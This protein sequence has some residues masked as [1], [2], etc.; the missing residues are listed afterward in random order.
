[1]KFS[2]EEINLA[3]IHIDPLITPTCLEH[4]D[5]KSDPSLTAHYLNLVGEIGCREPLKIGLCSGKYTLLPPY[6]LYSAYLE[7]MSED[8]NQKVG[9]VIIEFYDYSEMIAV[10]AKLSLFLSGKLSSLHKLLTLQLLIES[11]KTEIELKKYLNFNSANSSERRQI[12]RFL[13]LLRTPKILSRIL[14]IPVSE[15][16]GLL[17][18]KALLLPKTVEIDLTLSDA[19]KLLSVLKDDEHAIDE[20][21]VLFDE[22]KE[23]LRRDFITRE[24]ECK[25]MREWRSFNP[26]RMIELAKG[27]SLKRG[28]KT[29][30]KKHKLDQAWSITLDN[31]LGT[32]RIPEFTFTSFSK[33][34]DQGKKMVEAIYISQKLSQTLLGHVQR[35]R[36]AEHGD[37][38]KVD[39]ENMK[40]NNLR[41]DDVDYVNDFIRPNKLL[42]LANKERFLKAYKLRAH[43]F[44][45]ESYDPC[46]ISTVSTA[47]KSYELWWNDVFLKDI[48]NFHGGDE[49]KHRWFSFYN[50]IRVFLVISNLGMSEID[51]MIEFDD[52][53][54]LLFS[55]VLSKLDTDEK[56]RKERLKQLSGL[57]RNLI[58]HNWTEIDNA[59]G[60]D[61]KVS[62]TREQLN[63]VIQFEQSKFQSNLAIQTRKLEEVQ[64]LL[65]ELHFK[66]MDVVEERTKTTEEKIR[67]VLSAID[68]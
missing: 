11:G 3:S 24:E 61:G 2:F 13:R 50:Y 66:R 4:K 43:N 47:Q 10:S 64:T 60:R 55:H 42:R 29:S 14:G 26:H 31:D 56:V 15:A 62:L 16:G 35:I 9:C 40:S 1:M 51:R 23:R 46:A 17:L 34:L 8:L 18:G 30:E 22:E 52:F 5:I 21:L 45:F 36:P 32:I 44:G 49:S 57:Q 28:F 68:T 53:F 59:L 39:R 63:S 41:I 27:I 54:Y 38:W 58:G 6:E 12:Q 33:D 20:Y 19:E 65:S 67:E 25:P 37:S 48:H 7:L